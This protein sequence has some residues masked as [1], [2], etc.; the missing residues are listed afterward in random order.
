[1]A[2]QKRNW[3]PWNN[4]ANNNI[5]LILPYIIHITEILSRNIIIESRS[6]HA[7]I[8]ENSRKV[9]HENC[10]ADWKVDLTHASRRFENRRSPSAPTLQPPLL[11]SAFDQ[12]IVRRNRLLSNW[13]IRVVGWN[14]QGWPMVSSHYCYLCVQSYML[15]SLTTIV[16]DDKCEPSKWTH[17]K[18]WNA[19][20]SSFH[21]AWPVADRP[22]FHAQWII[23]FNCIYGNGQAGQISGRETFLRVYERAGDSSWCCHARPICV[24]QLKSTGYFSDSRFVQTTSKYILMYILTIFLL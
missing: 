19:D 15:A 6:T 2:Q 5:F 9:L 17:S 23:G 4:F 12:S 20:T 18:M 3:Y 8:E 24:C 22:F 21:S 7:D 1:M 14:I 10:P 16:I 11:A 13:I